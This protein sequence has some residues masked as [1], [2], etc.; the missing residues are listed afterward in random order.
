MARFSR[1]VLSK[2]RK[3]CHDLETTLSDTNTL[4]LRIGMHSGPVTGTYCIGNDGATLWRV[5][6]CSSHPIFFSVFSRQRVWFVGKML[7]FSCL[8]ILVRPC[9]FS[10]R[11]LDDSVF[12]PL[13]FRESLTNS[14]FCL[15]SVNTASRMESNGEGGKIQ[16]SQST[17]DLLA[18]A[19]KKNWYTPRED[20]IVAKG[21]GTC[22][23]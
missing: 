23:L 22:S 9:C 7:A 16:I 19:G 20:K 1:D 12:Q 14:W 6:L 17:A 21:K 15:Y 18:Q 3:V 8:V 11:L 10:D 4:D 2:F 13:P 5:L